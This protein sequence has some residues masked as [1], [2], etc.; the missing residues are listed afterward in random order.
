MRIGKK[1]GDGPYVSHFPRM[2]LDRIALAHDSLQRCRLSIH[3]NEPDLG[4]WHAER[5]DRILERSRS[6]AGVAERTLPIL[7]LEE[8]REVA[9]KPEARACHDHSSSSMFR[10]QLFLSSRES[11]R[12]ARMRP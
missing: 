9:A 7:A 10:G 4:V 6:R 8:T 5:L 1:N 12:S 2:H 11:A 3:G